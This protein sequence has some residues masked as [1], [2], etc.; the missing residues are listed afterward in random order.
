MVEFI[1][2][3][4]T[5]RLFR[6]IVITEK[7]DGTNAA[8]HVDD[9]GRAVGAQSRN[10]LITPEAD[11]YGF[12]RWVYENAAIL[13]P[14]LGSGVHFGEWWGSGIQ[15]G[16]G[17]SGRR[18]SLFNTDRHGDVDADIGGVPVATVPVLYHGS[19]R[20]D[21]IRSWLHTLADFGSVAAPGFDNP[22]GVCVYHTQT[23]SVFK[24]TLD[25]NDAG[26]WE[27]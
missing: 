8:I 13:G 24:M 17:V 27:A 6:D 19:F 16:Y 2:W 1:A 4:K 22:E 26:K 5:K 10:R 14:L 20:E 21:E 9:S 7:I 25:N 3:P 11:N 23:R 15:R 18:F 12:A